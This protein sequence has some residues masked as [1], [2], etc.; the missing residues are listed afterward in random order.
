[1]PGWKTLSS[2]EVYETPWIRVRRDEVLTHNNKKLTYSVISLRHPSVFIVATNDKDEFYLQQN[3]RY[4]LDKTLWN[5]PAGHSDGEDLLA[6]AKRELSEETGLISDDWTELGKLQQADGIGDIPLYVFW[7]RNVLPDPE[8]KIDELEDIANGQFISLK[9][10]KNM[11]RS[12]ELC[13]SAHIAA[14]YLTMLHLEK[15]K[16]L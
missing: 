16:E 12:G 6:A 14:V 1:M 4:C 13:E 9:K 3:Y 15:R 8:A 5:M 7:A 11:I 10:I 2:E